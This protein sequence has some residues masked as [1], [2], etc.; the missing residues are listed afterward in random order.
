VSEQRTVILST[1]IVE[2]VR[3]LCKNMAIMNG[4]EIIYTGTPGD[5]IAE[6]EGKVWRGYIPKNELPMFKSAFNVISERMI[7]GEPMVTVYSEDSMGVR[8]TSV[9]PD[10]E[11]V[12]FAQ[13]KR[14]NHFEKSLRSA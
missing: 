6:I 10:L 3:E 14:F 8:L 1:Q 9:T 13:I 2:D 7:G 11:D 4:G 5:A 12:Y